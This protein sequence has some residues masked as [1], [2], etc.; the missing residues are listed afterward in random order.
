MAIR[1]PKQTD[2]VIRGQFSDWHFLDFIDAHTSIVFGRSP[3]VWSSR[4][5]LI[6]P[7]R[8]SENGF[9]SAINVGQRKHSNHMKNAQAT[10]FAFRTNSEIRLFLE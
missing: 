7:R 3:S 1:Y 6:A 10:E 2:R 9:K 8:V 5:L 4:S